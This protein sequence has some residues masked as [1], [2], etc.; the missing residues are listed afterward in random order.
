MLK[1]SDKL[2]GRSC[3]WVGRPITCGTCQF[4][5]QNYKHCLAQTHSY[6]RLFEAFIGLSTLLGF[7]KKVVCHIQGYARVE[8]VD[9][10]RYMSIKL[11]YKKK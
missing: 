1:I 11:H 4:F 10:R 9:I 6:R 2:L 8:F 7:A 3:L 5:A